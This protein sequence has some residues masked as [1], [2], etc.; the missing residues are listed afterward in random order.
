MNY[1]PTVTRV[2]VRRTV[3]GAWPVGFS[4]RESPRLASTRHTARRGGETRR[5]DSPVDTCGGTVRVASDDS[6][7]SVATRARRR[8]ESSSKLAT[9]GAVTSQTTGFTK[10]RKRAASASVGCRRPTSVHATAVVHPAVK[11][12]SD[13]IDGVGL[14]RHG[15]VPD[16]S[17]PRGQAPRRTGLPMWT[18]QF[19]QLAAGAPV[20]QSGLDVDAGYRGHRPR[21]RQLPDRPIHPRQYHLHHPRRRV[22]GMVRGAGI[23]Y[24]VH[25][26]L[27][28]VLLICFRSI[29]STV[30]VHRPTVVQ[31]YRARGSAR[32]WRYGYRF[33]HS[34]VRLYLDESSANK[35]RSGF[36]HPQTNGNARCGAETADRT[37]ARRTRHVLVRSRLSRG[38][39]RAARRERVERREIQIHVADPD[40]AAR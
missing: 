20:V 30:P 15:R 17:S 6:T 21:P 27:W 5:S 26:V 12:R 23:L 22:L 14:Q 16:W 10:G 38:L 28:T 37:G 9:Y 33:G 25:R 32:T 7:R 39:A 11:T 35:F 40:T 13:F 34:P 29:Q 1:A 2:R 18:D 4:L 31:A 3:C 24:G 8:R 19:T 36:D